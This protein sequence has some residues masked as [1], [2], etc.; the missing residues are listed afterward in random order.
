M[1]F[2]HKKVADGRV[3][4]MIKDLTEGNPQKVLW[5]FT[6]PM[7]ISVVFQQLYNIADSVIAGKFAGENALAAVGA[8]YPITMIFMAIAV[9]SNVG[10][11]VV[12]SQLF[13]AKAYGKMKTA[14]FT[15]L[16]SSLV[17]SI[18][19]TVFGL[20]GTQGLMRMIHTP[21]NIF[22]D[23]AL[24]LRIYIGGF[25]FLF[26]YNVATGIFTSL[27]D[28]KTPL[29]FLIGSSLGNIGLDI[30]FVAGFHWGVAGVAWATFLAQ[31]IACVLALLTLVRR[32]S[33]IK[34]DEKHEIFSLKMLKRISMVAVPSI[35]QQSFVSVGNIF[36]Q[37]L[38]NSF[39][40]SV[41]A[42]YSAAI[43][44]NT[45]SITCFTT[46]GNGVSSF[47]AQNLGA[48][49]VDRA[50]KGLVSGVKMAL[51]IAVP[52]FIAFF[53]FGR[54]M[55]QLFMSDDASEMALNT[56]IM[57]LK[58][59][60]PFYFVISIKLIM[61]GMLR[62]AGAMVAFMASTLTDLVLRVA[63]SYILASFFGVTGIWMSWPVGWSIAA[64][65][66]VIFYRFG[67]WERRFM[68]PEEQ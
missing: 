38:V 53:I 27:G 40:S 26:L 33:S 63:L 54:N 47:S 34:T 45:F 11:A 22:S 37:S 19:L 66:S 14:V 18:V 58:I 41:I 24:Y 30:W 2:G 39:G 35:L 67:H 31:S 29:Y 42:G 7:F 44:L 43:K 5:Q 59:A 28:S 23:G 46:L 36:I 25:L 16:I 15:T 56:G 4:K 17:L 60:S 57:F 10:C 51:L 20:F 3:K 52:F 61:D 6:I 8:S 49:K 50:R 12:I 48:G 55:V 65:L 64:I 9:G 13:G 21:D 62:G 1:P 32:L 68:T